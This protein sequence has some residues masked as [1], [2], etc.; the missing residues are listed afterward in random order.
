MNVSQK[1]MFTE[2]VHTTNEQRLALIKSI[3]DFFNK[4]SFSTVIDQYEFYLILDETIS[5]A[6]EHGNKWDP[7][8]TVTVDIEAPSPTAV[9]I[10][11]TDEGEGFD[12]GEIP[13]NRGKELT[14]LRGRGI[15]IIKKFCSAEWNAT[16]NQVS[17]AIEIKE[18][19][20]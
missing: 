6:M 16:G 4:S 5:N 12:P 15:F 9:K 10:T 13:P 20:R 7:E 18:I 8:K 14:S 17:L 2:T 11:I 3:I 1:Y 19:N